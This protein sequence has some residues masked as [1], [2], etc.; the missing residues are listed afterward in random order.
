MYGWGVGEGKSRV[1]GILRGGDFE[2]W[3]LVVSDRVRM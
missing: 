2:G 3:R 1:R